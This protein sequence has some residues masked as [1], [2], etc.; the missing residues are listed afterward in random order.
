MTT[1]SSLRTEEYQRKE[2][3]GAGKRRAVL[4][5]R[6]WRSVPRCRDLVDGTNIRADGIEDM[7]GIDRAVPGSAAV[8]LCYCAMEQ[9]TASWFQ[10][11]GK[12]KLPLKACRARR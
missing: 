1:L 12:V 5:I 8:Y 4:L 11:R 7:E 9:T 10:D 3:W 6:S 2:D